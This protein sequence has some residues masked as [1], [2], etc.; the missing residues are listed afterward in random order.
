MR[1][2]VNTFGVDVRLKQPVSVAGEAPTLQEALR[3]LRQRYGDELSR[4]LREDVS[5]AEG[6]AVLLNGRNIGA[7]DARR[8]PMREGDELTFTVQVSGG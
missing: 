8:T 6:C 3:E 5:I 1:L 2:V 4:F 7:M